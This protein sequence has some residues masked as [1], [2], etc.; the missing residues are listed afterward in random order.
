MDDGRESPDKEDAIRV[1][2]RRRFTEDGD[3]RPDWEAPEPT[4]AAGADET[5]PAAAPEETS[6]AP[7]SAPAGDEPRPPEPESSDSS[8]ATAPLFL[9]L[10][11]GLA[12]Q[13][14][15]FIEGAQGFPADPAQA[16]RLIDYLGVLETKTRGNLSA[17]EAQILSNIVFQLRALFVQKNP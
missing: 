2:D 8:A 9:D 12:Q 11:N 7:R 4:P 15:L 14:A 6:A 1:V 3:L 10:V 5:P 17:E 16:Q 13:A